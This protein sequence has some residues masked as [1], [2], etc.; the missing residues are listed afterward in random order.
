LI[1]LG[2]KSVLACRI[3]LL[4]ILMSSAN[5]F[6]EVVVIV[7]AKSKIKSMS[8]SQ[9]A[10]IFLGKTD[11]FPNGKDAVPLDQAE[12]SDIRKEFYSKVTGK[13]PA[14]INAYWSKIIF[15]GEGQPPKQLKGDQDVRRSIERNPHAIGYIDKKAVTRKVK[16]ILT[17]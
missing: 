5:A 8:V 11:K 1:V 4:V 13:D 7:S 15:T 10:Q 2:I 9:V 12:G 14:Q 6:A 3:L 16:I 17:P